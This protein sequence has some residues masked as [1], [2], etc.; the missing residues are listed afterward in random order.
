M[1]GIYGVFEGI[2]IYDEEFNLVERVSIGFSYGIFINIF[3]KLV[4]KLN[5]GLNF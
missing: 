3:L 5:M 2:K 1:I 4:D